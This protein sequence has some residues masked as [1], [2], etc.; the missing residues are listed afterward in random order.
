MDLT[1]Y[2]TVLASCTTVLFMIMFLRSKRKLKEMSCEAKFKD[3]QKAILEIME[4]YLKGGVKVGKMYQ[5]LLEKAVASIPHAQAG[6]VLVK[7]N[8]EY[9]YV[10]TVGYDLEKLSQ[11]TYSE[12]EIKLWTK[13]RTSI[14]RK[15]DVIR[16]DE[17]FL[18]KERL[19]IIKEF[20]RLDEIK[21]N[22]NFAVE[23]ANEL[24]ALFNIDNF[25]SEN[26][27][28]EQTLEF[29]KLFALHLGTIFERDRLEE[30]LEEERKILEHLSTH[31]PLTALMNRRALSRYTEKIL[32]LAKRQGK[33]VAVMFIDL[34]RFKQLNDAY[35]HA[36]GD[37]ALK[38]IAERLKRSVRQ[39]DVVARIGGDEFIVVAYDCGKEQA[40]KLANRIVSIIEEPIKEN[41]Q[42]IKLS[43]NI[44]VAFYPKDGQA[45]DQLIQAADVAMYK[46]KNHGSRVAFFE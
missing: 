4:Q 12:E 1:F 33:E 34:W 45:L 32:P 16:L 44:G 43:C 28:D 42:A 25:E 27:F 11:L 40:E 7:R 20:G 23:V 5:F 10:A 6:S 15:N 36:I 14:N 21:C 39:E 38:V 13:G 31:D 46:T 19:R 41:G 30:K 22:V 37:S 29:A 18:D 24:V 2:T 9:V 3:V 35:G 26:A 8:N 17:G